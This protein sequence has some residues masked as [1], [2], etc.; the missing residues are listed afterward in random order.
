MTFSC[1]FPQSLTFYKSV[2]TLYLCR[3]LFI[4]TYISSLAFDLESHFQN[5]VLIYEAVVCWFG[6]TWRFYI[7]HK[8][9]Q[10]YLR[11]ILSL[12]YFIFFFLA[13]ELF[14]NFFS[15]IQN[16]LN[17]KNSS[18]F[19]RFLPLLLLSVCF[20]LISWDRKT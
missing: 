14:M 16:S 20:V 6:L 11:R 19:L 9:F 2:C 4:Y 7:K 18:F 10:S 1:V 8:A 12:L 5:S 13:D 3:F 17:L 15:C